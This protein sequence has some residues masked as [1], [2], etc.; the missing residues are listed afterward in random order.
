MHSKCSF[1]IELRAYSKHTNGFG[2]IT[3]YGAS[4]TAAVALE[5]VPCVD[6]ATIP[7]NNNSSGKDRAAQVGPSLLLSFL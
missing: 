7:K 1:A 5:Q 3:G 4:D 2:I 6:L